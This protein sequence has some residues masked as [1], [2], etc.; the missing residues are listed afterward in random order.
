MLLGVADLKKGLLLS[1]KLGL[2][3]QVRAGIGQWAM[4]V[5]SWVLTN[6]ELKGF[7]KAPS[8]YEPGQHIILGCKLRV[9]WFIIVMTTFYD[10]SLSKADWGR[11][12]QVRQSVTRP[13][14]FPE[15]SWWQIPRTMGT[16]YPAGTEEH[17]WL[18]WC[19]S[20]SHLTGDSG[21]EEEE[22]LPR[23]AQ[24]TRVRPELP[25]AREPSGSPREWTPQPY[26]LCS[27]DEKAT[28]SGC[29]EG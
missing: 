16:Q 27:L 17:L 26:A 14:F 12:N 3:A 23:M 22:A 10:S 7:T 8:T 13:R 9:T 18:V 19:H 11:D 28:I 5:D 24:V 20:V 6:A 15:R 25:R 2:G 21:R 4:P 1:E 29:H